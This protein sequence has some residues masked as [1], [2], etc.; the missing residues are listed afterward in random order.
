MSSSEP[1]TFGKNEPSR[2][3][4]IEARFAF[5]VLVG[6]RRDLTLPTWDACRNVIANRLSPGGLVTLKQMIERGDWIT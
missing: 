6:L 2:K 5:D 3:D 4:R 1:T